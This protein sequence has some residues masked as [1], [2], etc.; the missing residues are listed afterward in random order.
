MTVLQRLM[1]L[2]PLVLVSCAAPRVVNV[3]GKVTPKGDVVAGTSYTANLPTNTAKTMGKIVTGNVTDIT[4]KDSITFDAN[5]E[6]VNKA[7]IAYAVDPLG[8]GSDFYLRAGVATRFE[9]GYKLAGKANVFYGQYQ[10]L[11]PTGKVGTKEKDKLYGSVGLQYSWQNFKLPGILSTLQS[12]LGYSFSRRDFLLPVI[13]SYSLGNEEEYGSIAWGLA[14]S[15][16]QITYTTLP[17][18]VFAD[19]KTLVKGTKFKGGYGALGGFINAKL[20]YKYV[21][22]IPALALYYQNYGSYQLLNGTEYGFKGVTIIPSVS[23]QFRFGKD[24]SSK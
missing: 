11:G 22:F 7:A 19:N 3:S 12:R 23:I 8:S 20:G 10:F 21:Y 18:R 14:Y 5:F 15:Y 24:A 1:Y 9:L 4:N 16:S 13:F 17:D 6:R 2:L